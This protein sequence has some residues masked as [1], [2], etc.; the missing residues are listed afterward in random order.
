LGAEWTELFELLRT[1]SA[2]LRPGSPATRAEV[3]G[4]IQSLSE[5]SPPAPSPALGHPQ[6]GDAAAQQ[7]DAG[8]RD[9][10][11]E[12]KARRIAEDLAAFACFGLGVAD[13]FA[14]G[15]FSLTAVQARTTAGPPGWYEEL[16]LA[17]TE[18]SI[19]TASSRSMLAR[20][21]ATLTKVP[22]VTP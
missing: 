8:Q 16:A 15:T 7:A 11:D 3:A 14:D 4:V 13:A 17:R 22:V 2:R 19:S 1:A 20:F 18:L 10:D 21:R 5:L 6:N 12:V 9:E